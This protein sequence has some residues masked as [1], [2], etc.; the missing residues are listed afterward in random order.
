V[1]LLDTDILTIIQTRK[2]DLYTRVVARIDELEQE[3][4]VSIVSLEEQLRGWL[5]LIAK[6]RHSE[7]E[8]VAYHRLMVLMQD[9]SNRH[10]VPFDRSAQKIY[11]ELRRSHRRLGA[12]DLKI[13]SIALANRA[14]L[15]TRNV[16]DFS[17]IA[18]LSVIDPT[19][20]R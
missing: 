20:A 16:S 4:G 11:D 13:A 2:G 8:L 15:A 6:A 19:Q 3:V 10:V 7:R 12:M 18:G 14:T 1:L 5:A 9:F 17:D